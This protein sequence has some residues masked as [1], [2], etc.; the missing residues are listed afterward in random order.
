MDIAIIINE[1]A[2]WVFIALAMSLIMILKDRQDVITDTQD[3][4]ISYWEKNEL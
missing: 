4:I 1:T 3:L 2:Q